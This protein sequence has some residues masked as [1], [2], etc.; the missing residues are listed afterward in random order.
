MTTNPPGNDSGT[1]IHDRT[2][3]SEG[4]EVHPGV[5][6][7]SYASDVPAARPTD[8]DVPQ[9]YDP[10]VQDETGFGEPLDALP[11]DEQL[12]PTTT[13]ISGGPTADS[14]PT[15]DSGSGKAD[16]AKGAAQDVAGDAKAKAS[17]V[18]GT[19]K[20]QAANVASEATDHAKQLYGQATE[21]LK[22]QAADQQQ[23]AAGGLRSIGE[24][25][26]RMAENDDEQG[27]AAKVV[28]DLSG[29]A[30]SAAG[31]LENRDP[32]S[33]LDEVKSFAA[34]RPGTF[35]AIAAGAGILAGR[36]TKA[37]ATEVK[38]EKEADGA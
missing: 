15:S 17:D 4:H 37:L 16:A 23:R 8:P 7:P 24:Q 20:E 14:G 22:E 33:L 2:A 29:R 3:A 9:V 5:T 32:G 1:P 12:P 26:G 27:I 13:G 6:V 19:A 25:L 28:R 10:Y 35:I 31:F 34:K 38:H 36:L 18:A 21:T 30:S 11:A